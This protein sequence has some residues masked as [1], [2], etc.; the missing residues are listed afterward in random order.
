MRKIEEKTN[1]H[2]MLRTICEVHREIYDIVYDNEDEKLKDL[3]NEA[4]ILAKKMD[5]KLRQYKNNYDDDWWEKEREKV[6][7]EKIEMRKSR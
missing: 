2:K 4:Y 6:I 1:S 3:V 5:A 7:R